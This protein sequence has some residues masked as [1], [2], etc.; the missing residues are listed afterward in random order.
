MLQILKDIILRQ[1]LLEGRRIHYV[2]GWDCHGLPIELRA[3][4]GE[5]NLS[6]VEIRKKGLH[7]V[8]YKILNFSFD[9]AK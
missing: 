1:K 3:L 9:V 4:G 6:P 7:Y 5:T 8:L 2:P